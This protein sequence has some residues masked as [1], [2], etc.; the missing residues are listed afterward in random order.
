M[1][2]NQMKQQDHVQKEFDKCIEEHLYRFYWESLG[3]F[4]W[5]RRVEARKNEVPLGK[6]TLKTIEEISGVKLKGKKMLDIG[7]GWGGYTVA[8]L[9]MGIDACGCDVDE[10]VLEVATLRS[11]LHSVPEKYL[12]APSEKLPFSDETFHYVQCISVLEHVDN[13]TV[14]I[15]E[16]IRVLKKGGIAFIS[17]P[18]Y[19]QPLELH[20][21]VLFPPKCPKILGKMYLILLGRPTKFLDTINYIDYKDVKT[22]LEKYR[23]KVEY[24]EEE[25][26]DIFR[27]L[28]EPSDIT[29]IQTQATYY[30]WSYNVLISKIMW[31]ITPPIMKFINRIFNI[32]YIYFLVRK[33]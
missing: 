16:L 17:A 26:N 23:V 24:I 27:S 33:Y 28:Y 14:S 21:K 29:T 7:C 22:E 10:K 11:K 32:P 1:Q 31:R 6:A 4:D 18:N 25:Y 30:P 19:W 20:Y 8:A 12:V 3:L 5:K 2:N 13:V 15:R 9:E